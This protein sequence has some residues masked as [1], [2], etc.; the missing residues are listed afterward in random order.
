LLRELSKDD[1]LQ[2]IAVAK[3]LIARALHGEDGVPAARIILDRTEGPVMK[4]PSGDSLAERVK[5]LLLGD[6]PKEPKEGK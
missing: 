5:V 6:K 1:S 3:A 2:A 4:H